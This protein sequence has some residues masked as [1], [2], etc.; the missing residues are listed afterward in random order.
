MAE[1]PSDRQGAKKLDLL[2]YR[3]ILEHSTCEATF[4]CVC[5]FSQ[6]AHTLFRVRLQVRLLSEVS[7]TDTSDFTQLSTVHILKLV[8]CNKF[9]VKLRCHR[10]LVHHLPVLRNQP[11]LHSP[12][13]FEINQSG[14]TTP[15]KHAVY[16]NDI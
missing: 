15:S 6:V 4:D 11:L 9:V 12:Y 7:L 3:N 5:I 2:S 10:H 13:R 1:P 14:A 8:A 16:A